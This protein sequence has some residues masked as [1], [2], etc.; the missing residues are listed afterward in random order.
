MAVVGN[1]IRIGASAA[2]DDYEIEKSLRFN[3]DESAY[4]TRSVSSTGNR[5]TWTI[6]FWMKFC[7]IRG[8]NYQSIWSTQSGDGN[9]DI[10]KMEFYGGADTGRQFSF[11][12]NNHAGTGIRFTTERGLRDPSTWYHIVIAVDTTQGTASNR[13]KIYINGEQ[14]TVWKTGSSYNH[15]PDEDYDTCVNLSGENHE[16]CRSFPLSSSSA[17]YFDGYL[18]EINFIDGSQLTPL[19]FGKTNGATGQWIPKEYTGSHGTNGYYLNFSDNSGTTASTLGADS[20]GNGNNFTCNNLSVAAG[21]GCDS[22]VDT[23]TNNYPTLNPLHWNTLNDAGGLS[24]GDQ[25]SQGNLKMVAPS[26]PTSPYTRSSGSTM[27]VNSGAWYFEVYIE[28]QDNGWSFGAAHSDEYA[29][30]GGFSDY[31]QWNP[32]DQYRYYP[33]GGTAYGA[34]ASVG[35]TLACAV[36]IDNNTIEFFKNNVSQ[37]EVTGIGISG[38]PVVLGLVLGWKGIKVHVN[39]GQRAFSYTPPTGFKAL[40]T[41]NLP[42]PTIKKGT[43]YFNTVL[44]TGNSNTSQNITWVG[45]QPDL[46]WVKCRSDGENHHLVDAVRGDNKVIFANEDDAERTGSNGNGHTQ[47]NLASDGF[48]LVSN[49][50]N[51][52]LNFGSR[53]YV[54]WNWKGGSTVTNDTGSIDSQV[55]ANPSAGFSIVT[56]TGTGANATI[57]HGLG[58]VP[59]VIFVKN[60]GPGD[61]IWLVYHSANTDAPETDYLRLDSN[62]ATGDDNSAWNDTAPTSSVF[63]VGTSWSS[64]KSSEGH[65][66]YVYSG[67]EGYSKFGSYTGNN[68]TDGPFV[69]TGFRPAWLMIKRTDAGSEWNIWDIKRITG[70]QPLA[71]EIRANLDNIES[72]YDATR[73]NDFLSNGFKLRTTDTDH[74]GSGASYI[75]MAFAELPFKYAN[76]R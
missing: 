74:N 46:V 56:Y 71:R 33:G 22:M 5:R 12:D 54:A 32:Y 72:G 61:R 52:E 39:F 69:Y 35:N 11:I 50:S 31:F 49:G 48:N 42:T 15:Q 17:D 21:E 65:V 10:C 62:A 63:S 57:G 1:N 20:S 4:L 14:E 58:V 3:Y 67:V 30:H 25:Y 53:D 9:G 45:F 26:S 47:L 29:S 37:G 59:D 60:R 36:D 34:Q 13:V 6:S 2:G 19:S 28:T 41:A 27:I 55:N 75:Y 64:N 38:K 66:A 23:P 16:W 7:D 70:E 68:S 73:Y 44:Y 8:Y 76:A 43:D 18:T 51:D 24:N 40:C